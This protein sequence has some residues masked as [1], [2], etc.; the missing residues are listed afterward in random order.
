M[1]DCSIRRLG[2][3]RSIRS[4]LNKELL[5]RAVEE[6]PSNIGVDEIFSGMLLRRKRK[7]ART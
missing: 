1:L 4:L 3:I 2:A 7:P 6:R 5:A